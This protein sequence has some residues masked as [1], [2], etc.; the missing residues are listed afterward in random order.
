MNNLYN[1]LKPEYKAMLDQQSIQYPNAVE[2][3]RVEL[4]VNFYVMDL[5][6][7]T[8]IS[9]SNFLTLPN[10]DFVTILNLFES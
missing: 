6:Y 7:G 2:A 5:T 9:L 8:A 1:R 10:Y 4:K 3:F